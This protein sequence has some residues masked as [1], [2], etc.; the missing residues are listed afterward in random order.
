MN[1]AWLSP[2]GL[3]CGACGVLIAD[4]TH[5]DILKGRMAKAFGV[6]IEDIRCNGCMSGTVFVYC[7]TCAV[8]KCAVEKGYE[9]CYRCDAFPC[10]HIENFPVPEGK[11]IIL[12][13]IPE[14]RTLGTEKW[15]EGEEKRYSCANC[16]APLFRGAR[17]CRAC[18]TPFVDI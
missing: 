16:G 13:S 14:W 4:R 18:E 7:R 9:G 1:R 10:G 3:Y 2:C 5:D 8:R 15:T 12:R 6:A 11:R 17:K